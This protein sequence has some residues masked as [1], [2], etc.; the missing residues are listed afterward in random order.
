[1]ISEPVVQQLPVEIV[2]PDLAVAA[3]E[4]APVAARAAPPRVSPARVPAEP[5][6]TVE[7]APGPVEPVT[8]PAGPLDDLAA[9]PAPIPVGV[10]A[11]AITD[12]SATAPATDMGLLA[13]LLA[14]LGVVLLAIWGFIAIGRRT[15]AR[16]PTIERPAVAGRAAPEPT[17]APPLAV[18]PEGVTPLASP[19]PAAAG[20]VAH[21]GAAVPLPRSVPESFEERDAL[22]RRMVAARPDRANPFVSPK[23]RLKRARLILQS[24]GRDFGDREPWID[25][26]QYPGNWSSAANRTSAAA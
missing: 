15:R 21:T 16:A 9:A 25:F 2:P 22:L 26:T 24:L 12:D 17:I 7:T 23:A 13:A 11:S 20:G 10:P 19:R 3:E 18:R 4:A 8:V 1:M 14:A 5:A 6:A